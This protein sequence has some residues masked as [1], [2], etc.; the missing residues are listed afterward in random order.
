[1]GY[2]PQESLENT[3]NTMGTLLGVHLIVPWFY[4]NLSLAAWLDFWSKSSWSWFQLLS[5]DDLKIFSVC[6]SFI[7]ASQRFF[8]RWNLKNKD[9]TKR[10]LFLAKR[11]LVIRFSTT[12]GFLQSCHRAQLD[13][14]HFGRCQEHH[15]IF[16]SIFNWHLRASSC[17]VRTDVPD[18]KWTDQRWSDQWIIWPS[19]IPFIGSWNNPLILTSDPNFLFGTSCR[20][21]VM[22]KWVGYRGFF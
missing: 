19:D 8:A 22:R 16:F 21:F 2:S 5:G 3:I 9:N 1:M 20:R 13:A 10:I 17:S 12:L 18:R 14:R 6:F 15:P 4:P 11:V 7:S